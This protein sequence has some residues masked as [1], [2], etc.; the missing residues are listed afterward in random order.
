[1]RA[2][3]QTLRSSA[4]AVA[5]T[6][7]AAGSLLL[8]SVPATAASVSTWD[9]VA[10]CE[11]SGNW[12]INTGNGYY[13]GLQFSQSTWVA[14][15]G[16]E[17]APYAHLATK[18]QQIL[19]GEKVLK[20]QGENAWPSCGPAAGL[21]ADSQDPYPAR[22]TLDLTGDG[23]AD[24]VGLQT[25]GSLVMGE[26][27]GDG[28]GNYHTISSGY[29]G[30]QNRLYFADVTGDGKADILGL[31]NDGT[32]AMGQGTGN[33]FTNIHTISSGYGSMEGRLYFADVTGDGKADILGLQTDGSIV[34]G[35]STGN[36]F[37]DYHEISSGY[38]TMQGRLYF[39]DVTGDGKADILGLQNDGSIA[40][41]QSNG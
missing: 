39:A 1:M 17:Y 2:L 37:T 11:S 10:Q 23:K 13:G 16:T 9:K 5:I 29:G 31:Q 28:F 18:Q 15:G 24:I 12:S 20:S 19:I 21:G 35:R 26:G 27:N 8:G 22:R 41:G 38:S 6:A 4:S 36:G 30:M 25:D 33:G 32:I 7:A 3:R 34:M 40:M 14:H